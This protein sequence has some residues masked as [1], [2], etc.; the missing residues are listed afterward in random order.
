MVTRRVGVT[1]GVPGVVRR[2]TWEY[3]RA[4]ILELRAKSHF[5]VQLLSSSTRD[6]ACVNSKSSLVREQERPMGLA[7]GSRI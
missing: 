4:Y 1:A 7:S 6:D 3:E 5:H 2:V